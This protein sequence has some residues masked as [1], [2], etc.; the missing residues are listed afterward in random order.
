MLLRK[1]NRY[2]GK[3]NQPWINTTGITDITGLNT[4]FEDKI[5]I[6]ITTHYFAIRT[7]TIE[8]FKRRWNSFINE[9]RFECQQSVGSG[10]LWSFRDVC[11]VELMNKE[12]VRDQTATPNATSAENANVTICREN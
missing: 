5:V 3:T 9:K 8:I 1:H 2:F 6:D 11:S 7:K 4:L 10:V 12:T